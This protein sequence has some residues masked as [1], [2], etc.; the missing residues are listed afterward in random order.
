MRRLQSPYT[1]EVNSVENGSWHELM[2]GFEDASLYQTQAYGASRYGAER[3][4]RLVV[5]KD[6]VVVAA[7]QCGIMKA[8]IIGS[9][10]AH[11]R[12]G[13][14]WRVKN[15]AG[16]VEHFRQAL[17]ALRNEYACRQGL[18]LRI[19]PRLFKDERKECE[20]I[21]QEEGFSPW[22]I[23]G[24]DR[25]L[26]V[27]LQRSLQELRGGM[28]R[29]WRQHLR[30]AEARQGLELAEGTE[31]RFFQE[32]LPVYREMLELKN[33][34][35]TTDINR[36]RRSQQSLPE[37][38]KLRVF[39]CRSEGK[40]CAG[41]IVSAIGSIGVTL[42]SATNEKGR[43]YEAS[44][45]VHW[46]VLQWLKEA[47]CTAYDM[48]GINP[49]R[50]PGTY[51]YKAGLCGTN[52]KD[53]FFL[54]QFEACEGEITSALVRAGE[55]F[56]RSYKKARQRFLQRKARGIGSRIGTENGRVLGILEQSEHAQARG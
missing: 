14:L 31:D 33:L 49:V 17:R 45:L 15:R 43:K 8:L 4:S 6:G 51:R 27:D 54:G 35:A 2:G 13:P 11:V 55:Q 39:L 9:G 25:T 50:N 20:V 23:G 53:V 22:K 37:E 16:D 10:V 29:R 18:F 28:D 42:F 21:L 1:S 19:Y 40:A 32:F 47:G 34:A 24:K 41:M 56:I 46:R 48:D 38:Q 36:F 3:L 52:G 12:W 7:A 44:Y 26:V 30:R 5:K